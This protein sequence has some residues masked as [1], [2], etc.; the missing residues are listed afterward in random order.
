MIHGNWGV[1]N[2]LDAVCG[3]MRGACACVSGSYVVNLVAWVAWF[4]FFICGLTTEPSYS[5]PTNTIIVRAAARRWRR[6]GSS[7]QAENELRQHVADMERERVGD[8]LNKFEKA[9]R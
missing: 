3:G 4:I 1:I 5:A 2:V 7:E 6:D 8:I 9:G